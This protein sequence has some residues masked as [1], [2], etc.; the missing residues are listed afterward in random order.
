MLNHITQDEKKILLDA[1]KKLGF[2]QQQVADK[3]LVT[4]SQY[5]SFEYGSRKLSTASFTTASRILE[6]LELDLS[7][8]A[9][10]GY[11]SEN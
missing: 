3:A 11:G 1:R 4:L 8:F 10:G 9:R 2:T 6:A 7:T 5:Q